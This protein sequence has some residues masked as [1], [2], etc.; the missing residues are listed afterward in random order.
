MTPA[1]ASQCYRLP[2]LPPQGA[3]DRNLY[4]YHYREE[5]VLLAENVT[6]ADAQEYASRQDTQGEGWFVGFNRA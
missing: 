4:L 3:G 6:L 1:E 5:T 2:P